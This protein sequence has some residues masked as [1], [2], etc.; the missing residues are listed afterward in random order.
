MRADLYFPIRLGR[1]L[2]APVAS[3]DSG[4]SVA[5]SIQILGVIQVKQ[6]LQGIQ[7]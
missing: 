7:S 3:R 5:I 2:E 1:L 6:V 4:G